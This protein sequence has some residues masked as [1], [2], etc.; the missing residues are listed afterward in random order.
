MKIKRTIKAQHEIAGFALIIVIVS[1]IG[2]I[3]LGLTINTN[4][5]SRTSVEVSDFIQSSMY[6]TTDCAIGYVPNYLE[7][8]DLIKSC[9]RNQKCLN[10]KMS[11]DVLNET[12]KKIVS[13]SFNV[14]EDGKYKAYKLDIYYQDSLKESP[15]ENLISFEQGLFKNCSSETGAR[16]PI[17]MDSGNINVALEFCY[18]K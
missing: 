1:I 17:F 13:Q 3:F 16:Q 18:G 4:P 14:N 7:L 6:Y 5:Q 11:C 8:K 10:Q 12:M 15:K 9:Y 2:L